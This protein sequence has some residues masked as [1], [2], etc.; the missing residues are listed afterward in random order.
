MERVLTVTMVRLTMAR[1]TMAILT[2]AILTMS[3]HAAEWWSEW[4]C[5]TARRIASSIPCPVST[6]AATVVLH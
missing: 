6:A 3:L 5:R 2:M 4:L 1:L